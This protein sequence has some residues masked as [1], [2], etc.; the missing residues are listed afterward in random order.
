MELAQELAETEWILLLESV[1]KGDGCGE[2]GYAGHDQ[3]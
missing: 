3:P 2:L 1:R